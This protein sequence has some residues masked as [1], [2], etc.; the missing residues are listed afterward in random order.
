MNSLEKFGRLVIETIRDKPIHHHILMQ[1]GHWKTPAV[2]E[3]QRALAS[4][5]PEQKELMLKAVTD[6]VD[7]ALHYFLMAL[8]EAHD[9]EQ[10]IEVRV[11]GENIAER[12]GM[13]H[14]EHFGEEG[15]IAK[16]SKFPQ[17]PML[18]G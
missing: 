14:G 18:L 8:Q 11:D 12:S 9:R 16:F 1:Q 3:L 13:L 4:L 10:G 15:W 2:Q 6:A 7:T 5:P 17:N